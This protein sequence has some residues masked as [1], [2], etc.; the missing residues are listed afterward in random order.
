MPSI[1]SSWPELGTIEMVCRFSGLTISLMPWDLLRK[2]L[3][4][5]IES[6]HLYWKLSLDS[7]LID[8]SHPKWLILFRNEAQ[9]HP[10]DGLHMWDRA[11]ACHLSL[12]LLRQPVMLR[13]WHEQISLTR[14]ANIVYEAWGSELEVLLVKYTLYNVISFLHSLSQS[15]VE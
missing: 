9:G 1:P 11:S 15:Q 2:I 10:D 5:C 14:L 12:L 7:C 6:C 13:W 4:M 3:P 8:Q